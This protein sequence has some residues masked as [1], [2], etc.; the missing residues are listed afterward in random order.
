MYNYY[1]ISLSVNS[2]ESYTSNQL[3]AQSFNLDK[4]GIF[5]YNTSNW[6]LTTEDAKML[7]LSI[8]GEKLDIQGKTIYRYPKLSLPRQKVDLL[9]GSYDVKVSRNPVTADIH[10][11]STKFIESLVKYNWN[12]AFSKRRVYEMFIKMREKDLL[13]EDLMPSIRKMLEDTHNSDMFAIDIPYAY[14][15]T[16]H[17]QKANHVQDV[18]DIISETKK[19]ALHQRCGIIADPAKI[20]LF[21]QLTK[22]TANIVLDTEISKKIDESLVTLGEEDYVNLTTQIRSDNIDDRSVALEMMA[23]CN[24]EESFDIVTMI[25]YFNFEYCKSTSNWN[26]VNVKAMKNR[27]NEIAGGCQRAQGFTYNRLVNFLIKQGKLTPF[28]IKTCKDMIHKHVL[29]ANALNDIW[30][31]DMESIYL[32]EDLQKHIIEKDA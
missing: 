22:T 2:V 20:K 25:Y 27:L 9:K 16:F 15:N 4:E 7:G 13:H 14:N 3:N 8:S 10:V 19:T 6:H 28:V 18:N 29:K 24:L 31:I 21:N 26:T 30:K 5:L 11:V 32:N 1:K 17:G 23:N 12:P